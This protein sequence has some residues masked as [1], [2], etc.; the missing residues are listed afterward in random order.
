MFVPGFLTVNTCAE[1]S[2]ETELIPKP[3]TPEIVTCC[4]SLNLCP[5]AVTTPGFATVIPE[6]DLLSSF[7]ILSY[8]ALAPLVPPVTTSPSV[9]A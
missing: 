7:E 8:V 3:V 6:I 2:C 4:P 9:N 5:V 1:E